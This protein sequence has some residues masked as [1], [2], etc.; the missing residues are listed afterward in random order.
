M[1]YVLYVNDKVKIIMFI[2]LTYTL[3][4]IQYVMI[5]LVVYNFDTL[6]SKECY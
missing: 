6:Q 5:I 1:F 4:T 2:S 3:Y